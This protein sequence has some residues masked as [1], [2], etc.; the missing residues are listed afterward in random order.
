M[1]GWLT[2]ELLSVKPDINNFQSLIK[3]CYTSNFEIIF[4][5]YMDIS[6]RKIQTSYVITNTMKHD[7]V[8]G[9]LKTVNM[10]RDIRCARRSPYVGY[11]EA[12]ILN[13]PKFYDMYPILSFLCTLWA[14]ENN[15]KKNLYK[16]VYLTSYSQCDTMN[17]HFQIYLQNYSI[18]KF[19][20]N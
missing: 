17:I 19:G 18:V 3:K 2:W 9:L 6:T 13:F 1:V 12:D 10:S 20:S 7:R 11:L 16:L 4:F 14:M 15:H 8:D 5:V